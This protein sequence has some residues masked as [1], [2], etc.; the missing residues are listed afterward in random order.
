[1]LLCDWVDRLPDY[2]EQPIVEIAE[3]AGHFVH[4]EQSAAANQ[5][6]KTFFQSLEDQ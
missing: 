1:V 2:F 4:F 5:R 6:I 3:N